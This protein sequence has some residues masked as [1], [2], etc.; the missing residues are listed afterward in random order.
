[1]A[2]G[3]PLYAT[4]TIPSGKGT[5]AWPSGAAAGQVAVLNLGGTTT[6][7]RVAPD[8]W[9]L[10]KHTPS[11]DS[12][13][14]VVTAADLAAAVAVTAYVAHLTCYSGAG[15][16]GA[17]TDLG[18]VSPGVTTTVSGAA[19]HIW[20]RGKSTL[21]PSGSLG[22]DL[23]NA[24]YNK[25]RYNC[26]AVL[27]TTPGWYGLTGFNGTDSNS[28]EIVPIAGPGAP[29]ITS[30][31]SGSTVSASAA[32]TVSWVHN[33]AQSGAQE[34]YR[35]TSVIGGVTN[36]LTAAGTWT[37]TATA[38]SSS[39]QTATI[40][41]GQ[42]TSG[43]NYTLTVETYEAGT[44]SPVSQVTISAITPPTVTSVTGSSAAGSLV[45][46][47]TWAASTTG[48]QVA[49]QVRVCP[50]ADASPASPVW[51]SGIIPGTATTDTTDPLSTW[52]NGGSYKA[53]V[54]VQQPGLWSAWVASSAF[55]VSWTAPATPTAVTLAQGSPPQ[56]TVTGIAAGMDA[57]EVSSSPDGTTWTV[58][59]TIASP[60]ATATVPM[61][62]APYGVA[63]W[64]RARVMDTVSGVPLWSAYRTTTSAV[65]STDTGAYLVADDGSSWL[66][67]C[68]DEDRQRTRAQDFVVSYGLGAT[69]PRVDRSEPAG[70]VGS[71]MIWCSTRTE[72]DTILAWID[73]HPVW[74]WRWPADRA[75]T[76][77]DGGLTRASLADRASTARIHQAGRPD[78]DLLIAWVEQ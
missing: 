73:A 3:A 55:A 29:T 72:K 60:G 56:V 44:W 8:G 63:W 41:A 59:A 42:L 57:L 37:T 6:S 38:V 10:A 49:Y 20:G 27:G 45:A 22:S 75:G 74:I 34:Q 28:F 50:A 64:Y 24:A 67:V 68:I 11:T 2:I 14:R 15:R 53:W 26:W 32:L 52:V 7:K 19:A 5:V 9:L 65:A 4:A 69:R 16:V 31:A 25:R 21:T 51:D 43:T 66:A 1:M 70:W 47:V 30:P 23:I 48:G 61:P 18:N 46:V 62:L 76:Y 33:S 78:R 36:Y 17:V 77:A 35:I 71:E 40:S 58:I 39:A 13:W 54:R 12:Y